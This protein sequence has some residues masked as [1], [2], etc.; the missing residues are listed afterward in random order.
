[1]DRDLRAATVLVHGHHLKVVAA[2]LLLAICQDSH[3]LYAGA[4]QVAQKFTKTTRP[5]KSE[6]VIFS[7]AP[8]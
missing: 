8:L 2:Q 3:F 7:P 6:R 5:L 1:M 4:H